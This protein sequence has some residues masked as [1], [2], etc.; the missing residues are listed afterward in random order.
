[1]NRRIAVSLFI[2]ALLLCPS[3]AAARNLQQPTAK[4]IP[5]W[6]P[7]DSGW[8]ELDGTCFEVWPEEFM[9]CVW[10][11]EECPDGDGT[12]TIQCCGFFAGSPDD[13][14]PEPSGPSD[15]FDENGNPV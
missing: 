2:A 7:S 13:I 11:E 1:M 14:N 3:Y 12:Q 5:T 6:P 15:C 8:C 9:V 10:I 4:E